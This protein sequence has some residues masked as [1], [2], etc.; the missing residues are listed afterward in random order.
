MNFLSNNGLVNYVKQPT[1]IASRYYE[2]YD[3]HIESNT[4]LDLA[5]HN[6][7]LID[8]THCVS[9]PFSDHEF[10]QININFSNVDII[11]KVI[12]GRQL[13]K[14]NVEK[15]MDE[16]SPLNLNYDTTL[17]TEQ[18]WL[19]FKDKLLTTLNRI[20]PEKELKIK[21]RNL[22]PW[23]D[24]ELLH[25]K[26]LRDIAYKQFKKYKLESYNNQY[27]E[28]RREYYNLYNQKMINFFQDKTIND[29]NIQYE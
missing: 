17:K 26:Y 5:I 25:T 6:M 13:T 18:N 12:I 4:I 9:C 16:L 7:D 10:V 28:L 11:E 24:D 22:F 29:F 2:R 21:T 14:N 3:Q 23:V 8:S 1:R 19:Q 27:K 15:I 20:A